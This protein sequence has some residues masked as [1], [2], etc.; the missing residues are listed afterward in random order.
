M[1]TNSELLEGDR[2]E[3]KAGGTAVVT[4]ADRNDGGS[5][6]CAMILFDDGRYG[7]SVSAL[8]FNLKVI[9]HADK[10]ELVIHKMRAPSTVEP[11]AALRAYD[12]PTTRDAQR[13]AVLLKEMG[14]PV[15]GEK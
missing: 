9:G 11:A 6:E 2:V 10:R 5:S 7:G 1:T 4:R 14:R 12:Q 13:R 8:K 15:K 3:H